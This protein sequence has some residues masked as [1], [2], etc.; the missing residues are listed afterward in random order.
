LPWDCQLAPSF[1]SIRQPHMARPGR[2]LFLVCIRAV[3]PFRRSRPGVHPLVTQRFRSRS[4]PSV[5]L[6]ARHDLLGP[7][8]T[9]SA[10]IPSSAHPLARSREL[11]GSRSRRPAG[12]SRYT[13]HA[14]TALSTMDTRSWSPVEAAAQ[15]LPSAGVR[16][17][18]PTATC[19][20]PARPVSFSCSGGGSALGA[21][22]GR[23]PHTAC[24]FR[25]CAPT[26]QMHSLG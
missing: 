26:F 23:A 18:A 15:P 17:H 1:T 19:A 12:T 7:G 11:P 9:C 21:A 5:L 20:S 22:L 2:R 4:P 25:K 16:A 24:R 10:Y 8:V 3:Q 13:K 14:E 6:N